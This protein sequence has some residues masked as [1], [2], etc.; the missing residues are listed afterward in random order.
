MPGPSFQLAD[1]VSALSRVGGAGQGT[2]ITSQ[3]QEKLKERRAAQRAGLPTTPKAYG[4]QMI[5]THVLGL[6]GTAK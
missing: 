3:L 2:S 1:A 4:D 5:S 6:F